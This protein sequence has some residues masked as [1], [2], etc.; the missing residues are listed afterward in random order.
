MRLTEEQIA[1]I[2]QTVCEEAG[3]Q[4]RVWLF[5]SRVDDTARGGD[6]DLL[7]EQ[8]TDIDQPVSLMARLTVRISRAMGGRKVDIVLSAP[9][10]R[11][12]PIHASARR[13][14]IRL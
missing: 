12:M 4:S 14:G 9:N 1:Q 13:E 8:D 3:S 2:R 7:V 6:V 11:E 5:G 10:L